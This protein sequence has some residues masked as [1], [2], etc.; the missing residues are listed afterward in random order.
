[1]L[2]STGVLCRIYKG[3]GEFRTVQKGEEVQAGLGGGGAGR[4]IRDVE[5]TNS[6]H[7]V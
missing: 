3:M 5:S 2:Q 4:E 6:G 7:E 1:M